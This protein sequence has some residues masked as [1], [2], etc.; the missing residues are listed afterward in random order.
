MFMFKYS[1]IKMFSGAV[2]PFASRRRRRPVVESLEGRTLLTIDFASSF[3]IGGDNL[4]IAKVAFD[5]QGD[6]YLAGNFTGNVN[7]TLNPS[8]PPAVLDAGGQVDGFVAKYSS[9]NALQWVKP[10]VASG[11]TSS[12]DA[13]GLAVDQ[14]TGS[15]YV[16]GQFR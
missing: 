8:D 2:R 12:S 13:E 1:Y 9:T 6:T 7:F 10:F 3:S 5:A 4:N 11:S 15:V 16:A 14:A